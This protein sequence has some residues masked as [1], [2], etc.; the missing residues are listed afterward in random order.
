MAD[1]VPWIVI[2]AGVIAL[3]VTALLWRAHYVS[4]D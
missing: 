4:S 1:Y 2:A 3:I